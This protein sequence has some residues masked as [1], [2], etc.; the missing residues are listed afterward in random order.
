LNDVITCV[1][2]IPSNTVPI[3]MPAG[4]CKQNALGDEDS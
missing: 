4:S 3:S 2:N 1:Y